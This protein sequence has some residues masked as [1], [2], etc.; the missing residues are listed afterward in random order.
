MVKVGVTDGNGASG[1]P[2][3]PIPSVDGG[4]QHGSRP[5]CRLSP[6]R[7]GPRARLRINR[8]YPDRRA[9]RK[10]L[11]QPLRGDGNRVGTL[12][13]HEDMTVGWQLRQG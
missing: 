6:A 5:V 13:A 1:E 8:Q 2:A 9:R 4:P 3:V 12:S 11:A 7:I 10:L